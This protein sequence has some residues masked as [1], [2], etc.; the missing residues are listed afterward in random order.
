MSTVLKFLLTFAKK[1]FIIKVPSK[2]GTFAS[3]EEQIEKYS[4]TNN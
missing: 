1:S 3:K 2:K 4:T